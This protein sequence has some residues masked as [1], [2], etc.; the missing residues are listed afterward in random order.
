MKLAS[1]LESGRYVARDIGKSLPGPREIPA[2]LSSALA[3]EW[4]RRL[5]FRG[6]PLEK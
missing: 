3:E 5:P 6:L 2:T 4:P 1:A